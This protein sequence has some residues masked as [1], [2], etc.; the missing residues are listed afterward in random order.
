MCAYLQKLPTDVYWVQYCPLTEP[1]YQRCMHAEI[2]HVMFVNIRA[3]SRKAEVG[4][5]F[6]SGGHINF[7]K[8]SK[9]HKIKHVIF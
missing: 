8:I 2:I 1:V 3:T 5:L 7:W 9:G 4:N 6:V